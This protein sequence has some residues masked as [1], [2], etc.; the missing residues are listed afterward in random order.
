M[1]IRP[2]DFSLFNASL[3]TFPPHRW[4][5]MAALHPTPQPTNNQQPSTINH[6]LSTKN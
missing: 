2:Y 3:F 5:P 6:Q 1:A 4:R